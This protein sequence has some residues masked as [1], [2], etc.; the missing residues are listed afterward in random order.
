MILAGLDQTVNQSHDSID[1]YGDEIE[2]TPLEDLADENG[3][4]KIEIYPEENFEMMRDMAKEA[5]LHVPDH[6]MEC[7]YTGLDRGFKGTRHYY[8]AER[9]ANRIT[10]FLNF[11]AEPLPVK[12][13]MGLDRYTSEA[14]K[15]RHPNKSEDDFIEETAVDLEGDVI[16]ATYDADYLDFEI[17]AASPKAIENVLGRD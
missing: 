16:V 5:T 2:N 1:N 4:F 14:L 11:Y 6:I 10:D 7:L 3:E 13:E 17:D 9:V 8:D 15:S 12:D